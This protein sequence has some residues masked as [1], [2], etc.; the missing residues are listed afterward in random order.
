MS[1]KKKPFY[2]NPDTFVREV[3]KALH[4]DAK[5][6]AAHAA[7]RKEI[8]AALGDRVMATIFNSF[9]QRDIQLFEKMLQDHP[10]LEQIDA[11]L[12]IAPQIK[13]L[14]ERLERQIN[15][16]YFELIHD[17]ERIRDLML[18]QALTKAT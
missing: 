13:G 1:K 7:L 15:S 5:D 10:E 11:V 8:V 17:A 14:K 2:F 4:F 3:F 9:R 16:L 18:P 12:L 6:K